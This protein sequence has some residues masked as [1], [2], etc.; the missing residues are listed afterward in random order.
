MKK[1][2]VMF[3]FL[4][5]PL[6]VD[7]FYCSYSQQ[8]RLK[9]LASNINTSYEFDEKNKTFTIT[10]VNINP[11]LYVVNRDNNKKYTKEEVKI[12]KI[13][14]GQTIYFDVYSN[15]EFCDSVLYTI[16]ITLPTYN[17]YYKL[18]VCEGLNSYSLCQRWSSHGLKKRE[19]VDKVNKYK[20]SLI[21]D[22]PQVEDPTPDM[23]ILSILLSYLSSY[24]YIIIAIVIVIIVLIVRNKKKKSNVYR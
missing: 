13:K 8:A 3:I 21:Q 11:D 19:F 16:T 12:S 17:P 20:E 15:I 5:L 23:S 6:S 10:L 4:C 18:E 1:L 9:G 2:F 14:D 22:E 24:Y 7:A